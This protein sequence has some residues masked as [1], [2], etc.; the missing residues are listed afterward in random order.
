MKRNLI[1]IIALVLIMTHVIPPYNIILA[2]DEVNDCENMNFT[3][4]TILENDKTI[5][6]NGMPSDQLTFEFQT[7]NKTEVINIS[8]SGKFELTV[9]DEFLE[10]NDVITISNEHFKVDTKV[11]SEGT[12][13][14]SIQSSQY[15]ECPVIVEEEVFEPEETP[16]EL[17][18][19]KEVSESEETS[20][21]TAEE[22]SEAEEQPEESTEE[23]TLAEPE[24]EGNQ[25]NNQINITPFQAPGLIDVELLNNTSLNVNHTL[26]DN[27]V[28]EITLTYS[29]RGLLNLGLLSNTYSSFYVPSEIASL[30]DKNNLSVHYDV[31]RLGIIIP[32]LRN[33]GYFDTED[34]NI[35]GNHIYMNFFSLLSLNLLSP[36]EYVFTLT[37][38]LDE[39]PPTE[40][41]EYVFHSVT[42]GQLVDLTLISNDGTATALMDAPMIPDP[43]NINIPIYNTDKDITGNADSNSTIIVTIDGEVYSDQV[44][45][46]GTFTVDI[47]SQPA[48]T[49][50]SVVLENSEGY[51]SKETIVTVIQQLDS[52]EIDNVYSND[53]EVTGTGEANTTIILTIGNETY[54]GIVNDNG[55][56]S[57]TI[58]RQNPGT[59]INAHLEDDFGSQSE[60]SEASVL[61]ASIS[62]HSVPDSINFETTEISTGSEKIIIPRT[63]PDWTLEVNDT[64]GYGSE[65][66]IHAE[67]ERPLSTN[68]QSH[69]IEDGLV[70]VDEN[71]NSHTLYGES[72]EVFN[73]STLENPITSLTWP[74][75]QGVLVEVNP[76][77]M[78]PEEYNGTI[79]WIIVDGP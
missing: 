64:R 8:G 18:S 32:I 15:V 65:I 39:L 66:S 47:P 79:N 17:D 60:V 28:N 9:V 70:Y 49:Q 46:N 57:V 50:I 53:T 54:E 1:V 16:E 41:G 35:D 24:K 25:N 12:A 34:I 20:K 76:L 45:E 2:N 19:E 75:N 40:S 26:K 42:S 58:S 56:F 74:E 27:G 22:I 61:E 73:E 48:G 51:Q 69:V 5:V 7:K 71:L 21:E 38:E 77:T 13:S 63:N 23:K 43:P 55:E 67:A 44:A 78:Q 11:A 59:I 30:I 68:N 6:G 4:Q 3:V 52:P 37:I 14:Q 31:P 33:T 72:I 36:S 10:T 29:G 62:F